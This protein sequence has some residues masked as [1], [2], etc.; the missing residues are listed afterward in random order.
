MRSRLHPRF[1]FILALIA[2]PLSAQQPSPSPTPSAAASGPTF[3]AGVELVT[4][5]TV[6]TDKKGTPVTDLTQQ[7]F[8]L[9]ED[10]QA[11][12]IA[13]FEA[14]QLP[15][16][17]SQGPPPRRPAI[18]TNTTPQDRTAR[19]FLL[20]F[21]DIHLTPQQAQR[22]KIAVGEFLK[23]GV[24]DGDKVLL[25]NTAGGVWW[26]TTMPAGR[27][28]LVGLLKRLDGR[29]IPDTSPDRISDFEAMRIYVYHDQ[30]IEDR[31]SRRF[32]TYGGGTKAQQQAGQQQSGGL[33]GDGD[34]MVRARAAE[35]YFQSVSR[36]RISLQIMERVLV[37]MA[38]TRGRKSMV[39]VSEGFIYDPNL[40]EFKTV[41]QASRRSNTA[42]YFVDT[43]GLGGQFYE[44]SAEFGPALDERDVGFTLSDTLEAAAGAE[45]L[46]VDSGG[47]AVKNTND[48]ARGIQ[49]IAEESRV[50]YL[51][52]YHPTNM[53]ADGRFRKIEVKLA[54]KGLRVRARKGYYAP[55]SG[56]VKN[57]PKPV[58]ASDPDLQAA[59]D[60]PYESQQIGLRL[61]SYV[62]DETMLGRASTVVA[63]DID[64]RELAF[65]EKDGRAVDAVEVLMIV[66]HRETGEHFRYDQKVDMKLS[67][68]TRE[69]L[70]HTWFPLVR[71]FEL[72]P[73]GYQ[74]KLVVRDVNNRRIGSIIHE[75]EV[76]PL[77]GL[78]VSSPIV[79]DTLKPQED[80]KA[81]PRPAILA[82][83]S[84]ES[85]GT[86]YT[87][88]DVY[89]AM[90][91]SKSGM[92]RVTAGY[93]VQRVGGPT[94]ATIAPTPIRP[95][96]LGKLS[97]LVGTP[98][99]GAAPGDYEAVITVRDEVAG[100]TVE[101]REPFAIVPAGTLTPV[102]PAS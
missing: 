26:S 51:L 32:D 10:G 80:P 94:V 76:P 84:F 7:D 18:S 68:P 63:A 17:P 78:R 39:I 22:A 73:G 40:D 23:T 67:P 99:T 82:R 1:A 101:L 12:P 102:T 49:R 81:T 72:A 37:A 74:A 61:G 55:V 87:T 27:D 85:G 62:F 44:Q 56:Q 79:S 8:T 50:Y 70:S 57:A 75:F 46:A 59:L 34:P 96:S 38:S 47:F 28:D 65:E 98:L 31:V 95:T 15:A 14:V 25:V 89:G 35:V 77:A 88:Y 21:D 60:S 41:L 6:V 52:G 5:D 100:K 19:S 9:F 90:R 93:S 2:A 20:L 30:Q 33:Q 45:E 29:H 92:P 69:K 24:R 91:D 54:R 58:E 66:V 86:L 53:A 13:S 3:P 83:R 48:L 71:D 43:R 97:R 16:Q 36:T 4:V 64:I 11:Q 42:L